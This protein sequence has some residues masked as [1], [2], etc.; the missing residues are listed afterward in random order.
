[1]INTTEEAVMLSE[2]ITVTSVTWPIK[3]DGN[4]SFMLKINAIYCS[5]IYTNRVKA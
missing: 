4:D 2:H 5:I 1:M 3:L